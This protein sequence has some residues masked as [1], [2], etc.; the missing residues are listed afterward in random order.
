MLNHVCPYIW[1]SNE[2]KRILNT[3]QARSTWHCGAPGRCRTCATA[4]SGCE[5]ALRTPLVSLGLRHWPQHRRQK[6]QEKERKRQ[7]LWRCGV[8]VG[9]IVTK[10]QGQALEEAWMPW[11]AGVTFR[12]LVAV[13]Q[14]SV[15]AWRRRQP[16][17]RALTMRH[18]GHCNLFKTRLDRARLLK[19]STLES[20]NAV[21]IRCTGTDAE[22]VSGR[23]FGLPSMG[24]MADH[25]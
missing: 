13:L 4:T 16:S 23:L 11:E 15:A 8:V 10:G 21:L 5:K 1:F 18:C 25:P 17:G 24:L 19:Y 14:S 20:F 12:Q 9:W 22:N 6:R 2:F 3:T 7:K